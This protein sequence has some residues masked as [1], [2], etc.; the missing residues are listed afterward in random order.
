MTKMLTFLTAGILLLMVTSCV[1]DDASIWPDEG[2]DPAQ[3]VTIK[4]ESHEY[5]LGVGDEVEVLVYRQD[6]VNVKE[7]INSSGVI[8]FPMVGDVLVNGKGV[9]E[10]RDE[11]TEKYKRYFVNPQ[12]IVRISSAE[13]QKFMVTGEVDHPGLFQLDKNYT[14]SEAIAK[15]GGIST[16]GQAGSVL[17]IR[18]DKDGNKVR[19]VDLSGDYSS[20]E[21][22]G[23]FTLANGDIVYVPEKRISVT[24]R[25]MDYVGRLVM[26]VVAIESGIVLWPQ[27]QDALTGKDTQSNVLVGQ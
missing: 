3:K 19:K 2:L 5:V 12:V 24:A 18:R 10:L 21:L 8:M 25:F 11:L 20:L 15:A 6:S 14:V 13:S 4:M 17:L 7:K 27:V 23:D 9:F 16:D 1:T 22:S 26:P